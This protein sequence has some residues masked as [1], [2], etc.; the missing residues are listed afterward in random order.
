MISPEGLVNIR[1]SPIST[2][3]FV[4]FYKMAVLQNLVNSY[5]NGSTYMNKF[6]NQIR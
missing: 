3:G 2:I 5:V 1:A 4:E 6:I